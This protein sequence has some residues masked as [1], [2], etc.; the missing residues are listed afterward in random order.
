MQQKIHP[1]K[2]P[3]NSFRP[4]F[5]ANNVA[6]INFEYLKSQGIT[7]CLI[8]LDGTVVER[9]MVD[10]AISVIEALRKC[11]LRIII[12]TNRLQGK[13]LGNLVQDLS[14]EGVVQPQK[15]YAKP[16]KQY[17]QHA[18]NNYGL[19]PKQT[20]MIGDRYFQ[21]IFGS[22][23]VGIFSLLVSHIEGKTRLRDK[24][25]NRLQDIFTKNIKHD[26]RRI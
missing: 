6:D 19:N 17:Y 22:N 1:N 5:I 10:V 12:A 8:D 7:T 14:A 21:D 4:D 16:T 15:A 13:E 20:V 2:K 25:V 11:G 18:I 9:G 3:T 26:Y 24:L 23:R